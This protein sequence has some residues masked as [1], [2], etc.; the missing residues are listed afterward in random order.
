MAHRPS[1]VGTHLV[2]SPLE[3]LFHRTGLVGRHRDGVEEPEEDPF[4]AEARLGLPMLAEIP[5]QQVGGPGALQSLPR[6]HRE[7]LRRPLREAVEPGPGGVPDGH[8]RSQVAP[9]AWE[10][11]EDHRLRVQE[12]GEMGRD[13]RGCGRIGDEDGLPSANRQAGPA[14]LG[15]GIDVRLTERHRNIA[16]A[17]VHE[18]G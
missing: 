3:R 14:G 17:P 16:L 9:L 12:P 6:F 15:G 13:N 8:H 1:G 5:G 10:G 18:P 11:E 2:Q 4:P 7:Q